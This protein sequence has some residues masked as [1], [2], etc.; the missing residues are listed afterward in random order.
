[1]VALLPRPHP[2]RKLDERV[3][4][5]AAGRHVLSKVF[6]DHWSFMLG[7][8]AL[9]SFLFLV[10]TGVY[11]AL[12]FEPST[13]RVVYEGHYRPMQGEQVSAAYA[14][15]VRLSWD[16]RGGLLLRQAH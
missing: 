13:A 10:A 3:G 5:A 14:S 4:F 9:Y 2:M 12:F 8:V 6:P 7:E 11:L 1:M 15:A 16:V